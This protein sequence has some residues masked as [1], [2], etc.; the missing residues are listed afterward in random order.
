M[1][2]DKYKNYFVSVT[3]IIVN[4][5]F[6]YKSEVL[7]NDGTTVRGIPYGLETKSTLIGNS[8]GNLLIY[9]QLMSCNTMVNVSQSCICIAKVVI[10]CEVFNEKIFVK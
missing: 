1:T 6:E 4:P 8:F 7:L 10:N 2:I 3:S 9:D 5:D